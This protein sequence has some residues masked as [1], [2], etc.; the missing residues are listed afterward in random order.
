MEVRYDSNTE[1]T[2]NLR[3]RHCSARE[4]ILHAASKLFSQKGYEG[5]RTREISLEADV[6]E[7]TLFRCFNNKEK[8]FEEV[9]S[10]SAT[11]SIP[12]AV[13]P[14]D[15]DMPYEEALV[16]IAERILSI[17]RNKKDVLWLMCR[18]MQRCAEIR[19][20]LHS[21]FHE[22]N[23]MLTSYFHELQRRG[24]LQEFEPQKGAIVFLGMILCWYFG[25]EHFN[26]RH[27]CREHGAAVSIHDCV[28][29][30]AQGTVSSG[31]VSGKRSKNGSHL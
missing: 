31:P 11:F 12:E 2:V 20:P 22:L 26:E 23:K 14:E 16:I 18:E 7:L 21:V 9:I 19:N 1:I 28:R 29:F 10:A 30:F 15:L 4:R 6:A 3:T 13:F 17:F 24:V 5:T 25:A 8:L 27:A